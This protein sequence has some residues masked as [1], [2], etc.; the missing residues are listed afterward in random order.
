MMRVYVQKDV[1]KDRIVI[2]SRIESFIKLKAQN[3]KINQICVK[4]E[5]NS[6]SPPT[7][8]AK[9]VTV[10]DD[11]GRSTPKG[12]GFQNGTVGYTYD[13]LFVSDG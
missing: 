12:E 4:I 3:R 9:N 11:E 1:Q 2:L 10:T 8:A 13:A 7:V 6:T 5:N